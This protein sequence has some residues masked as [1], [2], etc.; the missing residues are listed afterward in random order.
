MLPTGF[1]LSR[2]S[3][4]P[5]VPLLPGLQEIADLITRTT[6][7]F[8]KGNLVMENPPFRG[9]LLEGP[10]GTGKT[11]VVRQAAV[12]LDRRLKGVF[13]LFVDGASIAAPRW[14]D[15]EQK[16]RQ[17]FAHVEGL[18]SEQR[19]PKLIILF[20]DI[21]SLMIARGKELAKEWHYSINSILFH[22]L[23]RL[24]PLESIVCATTNRPDL[25]D[26]ALASR[27]YRIEF[28]EVEMESL[29]QVVQEVLESTRTTQEKREFI[30]DTV[31]SELAKLKQ[32]TIRDA[33]QHTVVACIKHGVWS[34]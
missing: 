3:E 34:V 16:L 24:N 11:E 4:L 21:E 28:P 8:F 13:F 23:D 31:M 12:R 18:K 5:E 7:F 6:E 2:G 30:L 9:F 27:L 32:P 29:K 10:P 33:R 22:E 19:D 20:D 1:L 15:A 14:G 25:V 26:E 17:V